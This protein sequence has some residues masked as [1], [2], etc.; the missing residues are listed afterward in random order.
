MTQTWKAT[1]MAMQR[2]IDWTH[3][4][5]ALDAT[6]SKVPAGFLSA[7]D[8]IKNTSARTRPLVVAGAYD[9]A[10]IMA[11]AAKAAKSHQLRTG[12]TWGEAMSVALKGAWAVAKAARSATA[13]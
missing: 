6:R 3:A 7:R 4:M 9:R 11:A 2:R 10:A 13:N 8:L 1:A 5:A 12:A